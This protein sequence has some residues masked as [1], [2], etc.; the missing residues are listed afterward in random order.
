MEIPT[1]RLLL[2]VIVVTGFAVLSGAW[3]SGFAEAQLPVLEA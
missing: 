3:I 1:D 2:M